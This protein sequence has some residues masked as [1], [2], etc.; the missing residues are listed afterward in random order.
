MIASLVICCSLLG[1]ARST[2]SLAP[3]PRFTP[4][5]AP[6]ARMDDDRARGPSGTRPRAGFAEEERTT[7]TR[8][9]TFDSED[10]RTRRATEDNERLSPV[11]GINQK[12][13]PPEIMAEAL[14]TVP[15]GAF[16]P[17]EGEQSQYQTLRL[18]DALKRA[19]DRAQQI[20]IA[21]VYWRL[22]IA[23]ADYHF[24]RDAVARLRVTTQGQLNQPALRA[25]RCAMRALQR[26]A[27]T[28]VIRA[29]NALAAEMSLPPTS[30]MPLAV[31]IPHTGRYDTRFSHV[32]SGRTPPPRAY[33]I[34]RIL[35]VRR[36]AIDEHAEGIVAA[37][38]A[39]DASSDEYSQGTADLTTLILAFERL[40]KERKAFT[41]AIREYNQDIAEYALM[42]APSTSDA[43]ALVA[44]LI[45]PGVGGTRPATETTTPRGSTLRSSEPIDD[46]APASKARSSSG[47]DRYDRTFRSAP[48]NPP[49]DEEE[50]VPLKKSRSDPFNDRSSSKDRRAPSLALV[51]GSEVGV[52]G[53]CFAGA[54]PS[55]NPSLSRQRRGEI[56]QLAS[57]FHAVHL[58]TGTR[59]NIDFDEEDSQRALWRALVDVDTR[60]RTQRLASALNAPEML[61]H[62]AGQPTSLAD[63]LS[64]CP[65]SARRDVIAAFWNAREAAATFQVFSDEASELTSLSQAATRIRGSRGGPEAVIRLQALRRI[66]KAALLDAQVE[67]LHSQYDLT[68]LCGG[69]LQDEWLLPNTSPH[70]G[71]YLLRLEEQPRE[72]VEARQLDQLGALVKVLHLQMVDH[73]GTV[74]YADSAR[75]TALRDPGAG[76]KVFDLAMALIER[77]A[78]HTVFFLR[79]TKR[80][81]LAI[82]DYV[83]ATM[84][85]NVPADKLVSA[86][87]LTRHRD[88]ET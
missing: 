44:M 22:V 17:L 1:Q 50:I 85:E 78:S 18:V 63:C 20:K 88:S 84:P 45:K 15:E 48:S 70:G 14:A 59:R 87:V 25:A 42:V 8:I 83:L 40:W 58:Q 62:D 35:P 47:G 73:A 4:K 32:Y 81:N 67:M 23:Q 76:P 72:L 60:L 71:R 77:Q 61:P 55:Q 28:L 52:E 5:S 10:S 19:S 74:V 41:G 36:Q 79:A 39:V 56:A 38:D 21:Q 3:S 53:D 27:E 57:Y 51:R 6:A 43:N 24:A 64:M 7:D 82:A 86:L 49:T 13:R 66:V 11:G 68:S 80:Y 33:L 9:R 69:R 16:L 75:A 37:I 12:M 2:D 29:Q 26:D 31:D 54:A 65:V 46:E 34:D 30:Q